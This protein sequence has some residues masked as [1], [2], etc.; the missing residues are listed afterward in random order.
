MLF[1]SRK[2]NK[3]L[4]TGRK[5]RTFRSENSQKITILDTRSRYNSIEHRIFSPP[6]IRESSKSYSIQEWKADIGYLTFFYA[7]HRFTPS[8]ARISA[9]SRDVVVCRDPLD[10]LPITSPRTVPPRSRVSSETQ[11]TAPRYFRLSTDSSRFITVRRSKK[12]RL[13]TLRS[14]DSFSNR[15]AQIFDFLYTAS[16]INRS[17]ALRAR[18]LASGL[19]VFSLPPTGTSHGLRQDNSFIFIRVKTPSFPTIREKRSRVLFFLLLFI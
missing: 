5:F 18:I 10:F 7:F 16:L 8:F 15:V 13:F 3:V 1:T 11:T 9:T 12:I 19:N 17:R 6:P 2:S 4:I 14:I